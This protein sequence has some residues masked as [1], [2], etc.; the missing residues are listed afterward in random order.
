MSEAY[1]DKAT[2]DFLEISFPFHQQALTNRFWF[3][4]GQKISETELG[5]VSGFHAVA[6]DRIDLLHLRYTAG[7]YIEELRADMDDVVADWERYAEALRKFNK[8]PE[9]WAF[10]FSDRVQYNQAVQLVGIT[11]L[12]KREDLLPRIANLCDAFK[13]DDAI[14]DELLFPYLPNR[15]SPEKFFHA[16]PYEIVIDAIDEEDPIEQ[17]DLIKEAVER[18]YP[19]NAGQPFHDTHKQIDDNGTGGYFGYWCF[20]LAA[21]TVILGI[22]DS[23]F[24]NHVTYPKDLA[25]HARPKPDAPTQEKPSAFKNS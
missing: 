6:N 1:F 5:R 16:D 11:I 21:L 13:D 9:L 19:A 2:T 10:D 22:D 12:L 17:A 15:P 24:R 4:D 3:I 7:I 23:S 18:W 25:D 14:Y 20:E 8:Q